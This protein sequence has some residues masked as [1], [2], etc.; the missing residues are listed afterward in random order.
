M[1][2]ILVIALIFISF[3]AF[4]QSPKTVDISTSYWNRITDL[5]GGFATKDSVGASKSYIL[6]YNTIVK[7][8]IF[9]QHIAS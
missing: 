1:K 7:R 9:I 6:N 5:N 2:K 8:V 3:A 4:S